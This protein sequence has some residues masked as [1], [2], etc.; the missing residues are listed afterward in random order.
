[1]FNSAANNYVRSDYPEIKGSTFIANDANVESALDYHLPFTTSASMA[2]RLAKMT[3]FRAREQMT[4]T[5]EFSL[6]AFNVQVGD[7]VSITNSRYGFSAKEF[8]VAGWKFS[9][10]ASSGELKVGLTLRET[11]AAA[12]SWSAEESDIDSNNSTLTDS[13]GGLAISILTASGGGSTQSDGT[14]I[15]S[16]ILS[17]TAAQ[18]TFVSYYEIDWKPTADSNY[19]STTTPDTSIEISPIIDSVEYTIRVRAV[20]A[21]G[22]KGAYSTITFTG[23]G[24]TTAPALPTSITAVGG[25]KYIDINTISLFQ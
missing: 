16:V 9:N 11:S 20:T 15:N 13:R 24:D 5:A 18:N 4:L 25:F 3:L 22:V 2:Q 23:G 7:I 8:E 10:D 21:A 12:F 1:M 19:S 17:W 14:F 6:D